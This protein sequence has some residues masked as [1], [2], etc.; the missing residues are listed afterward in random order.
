MTGSRGLHLSSPSSWSIYEY[1]LAAAW[2]GGGGGSWGNDV[3]ACVRVMCVVGAC[4]S[5][6][7]YVDMG[8]ICV[9]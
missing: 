6:M 7:F 3:R 1:L 5:N 9:L 2:G 8:E 4:T